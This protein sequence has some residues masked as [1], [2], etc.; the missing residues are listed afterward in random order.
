ML[1]GGGQS[2]ETSERLA[3]AASDELIAA[4]DVAGRGGL[5]GRCA[6][7]V[8][9]IGPERWWV[10][11]CERRQPVSPGARGQPGGLLAIERSSSVH[12]DE[13]AHRL[14]H[15]RKEARDPVWEAIVVGLL[16]EAAGRRDQRLDDI[17]LLRVGLPRMSGSSWNFGDGRSGLVVRP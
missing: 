4:T 2:A 14:L 5:R 17:M 16:L 12:A 8:P 15:F 10:G 1:D 6:T 13:R 9:V 3:A 11:C 7:A